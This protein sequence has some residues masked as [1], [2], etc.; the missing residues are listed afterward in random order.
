MSRF[1]QLLLLLLYLQTSQAQ[2]DSSKITFVRLYTDNDAY[3]PTNT[4]IDWGYTNG[5]RIDVYHA[6]KNLRGPFFRSNKKKDVLAVNTNGWGV[7]QMIYAPKKTDLVIPDKNDYPY[8]GAL[9]VTYSFH[10]ANKKKKLNL[11]SEWFIG[12]MGFPS[13]AESTHKFF[14]RLIGDPEPKGWNYQLPADF[15]INFNFLAEKA[16]F[17]DKLFV[18]TANG[19]ARVGTMN[20]GFT[21]GIKFSI[22]KPEFN[23]LASEYFSSKKINI[24]GSIGVNANLEF[25]SALLQGGLLNNQ[26]PVHDKNS[27]YG[28]SLKRELLTAVSRATLLVSTRKFAASWS[29]TDN[30]SEFKNYGDH[31]Y[32]NISAYIRL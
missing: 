13:L 9:L 30:T 2:N 32:G 18:L 3:I 6:S 17:Q 11:N 16:L 28:T 12:L 14:H 26:S 4:S 20:D 19:G 24:S 1:V 22:G 15:L 5:M 8:S 25:Y 10:A 21:A 31:W 23:G 27:K 29:I 7:M